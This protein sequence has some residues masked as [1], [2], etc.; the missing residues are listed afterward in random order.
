[1]GLKKLNVTSIKALAHLQ[2]FSNLS[3]NLGYF[4]GWDNIVQQQQQK[5]KKHFPTGKNQVLVLKTHY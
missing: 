3:C 4:G 1:M 5:K 2:G